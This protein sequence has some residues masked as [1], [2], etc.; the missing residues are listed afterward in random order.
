MA[1]RSPQDVAA[2]R[3][4]IINLI[5]GEGLSVDEVHEQ[6]HPRAGLRTVHEDISWMAETFPEHL[7]REKAGKGHGHR[8]A[9]RWQ[10]HVPYILDK[11]ITWLTEEELI[12]LVAARGFL[13]ENGTD[14]D[15][16]SASKGASRSAAGA[17]SAI[18]P[19]A[20]LR[21]P[22]DSPE[23]TDLCA[24]DLLAGAIGRL[25]NRA[26]V[27]EAA[28]ILARHVVT[29]S[30]FGAAPIDCANLALALAA[31]A[32]GDCLEF[33]YENLQGVTREVHAVPA[34][35]VLIKGEWYCIAW[36]GSL[37]N[38]RVARMKS[39]RRVRNRPDKAPV[40]IP[41]SE[42]DA[43]LKS[44]F[45]AT[46]SRRPADRARV[47]LAVSPQAWPHIRDRRWGDNQVL[48]EEP[49]DLPPG[50]RRLTFTTTGL[51]ECQHWVLGMGATVRV[52]GPEPLVTWIQDQ[53]LQ[54]QQPLGATG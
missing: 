19:A 16:L 37:K 20:S 39:A 21:P 53:I 15:P 3:V 31:T 54:L 33:T 9:Y 34:R 32:T 4:A 1:N 36:A 14:Q 49:T 10:G 27:Q 24:C 43:L 7:K 13:R 2:R 42:V 25:L 30:R 5:A 45:F 51:A 46:A 26:G 52:E 28:E 12:G 41:G 17:Q 8:I 50:W 6:L 35:C 29:V 11:P 48:V 23:G 18:V 47:V 40:S 38:F 22:L 44:A